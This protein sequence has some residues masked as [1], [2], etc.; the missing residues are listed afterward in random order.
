VS[1]KVGI[2]CDG[3]GKFTTLEGSDLRLAGW[4]K[5]RVGLAL[6]AGENR[7]VLEGEAGAYIS[8]PLAADAHSADCCSVQCAANWLAAKW[9]FWA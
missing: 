6:D 1:E 7:V 8:V 4:R 5:V 9:A 3:C 2:T